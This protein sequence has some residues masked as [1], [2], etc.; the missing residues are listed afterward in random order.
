MTYILAYIL[1]ILLVDTLL[2]SCQRPDRMTIAVCRI[3]GSGKL[4][5]QPQR[6]AGRAAG[7]NINS[8]AE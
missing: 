3:D 4:D 1:K 5:R 8:F 7:S 6:V 2:F